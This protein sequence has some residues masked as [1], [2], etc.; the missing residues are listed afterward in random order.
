MTGE[1]EACVKHGPMANL[2][3]GDYWCDCLSPTT[4]KRDNTPAPLSPPEGAEWDDGFW[5]VTSEYTP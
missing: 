4:C 3:A 1:V 5:A 2:R